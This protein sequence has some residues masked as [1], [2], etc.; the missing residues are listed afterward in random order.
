[1]K[2]N[3][4]N[5]KDRVSIKLL[6]P[7]DLGVTVQIWISPWLIYSAIA[8]TL[9][10]FN[11]TSYAHV[12]TKM[13]EPEMSST[14]KKPW[15]LTQDQECSAFKNYKDLKASFFFSFYSYVFAGGEATVYQF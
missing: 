10:S 2:E 5:E 1:M 13:H 14:S 9:N 8:Q 11:C 7:K 12:L 6:C 3:N 4:I 15:I